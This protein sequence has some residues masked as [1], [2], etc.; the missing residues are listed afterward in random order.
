MIGR[1]AACRLYFNAVTLR[2]EIDFGVNDMP[3]AYEDFLG[4]PT[5]VCAVAIA[6]YLPQARRIFR[7]H[8]GARAIS[9]S[10]WWMWI[11]AYGAL[12]L[13]A[14]FILNDQLIA[15][16]GASNCLACAIVVGLTHI[17][18][19]QLKKSDASILGRR[20]GQEPSFAP[21]ALIIMVGPLMLGY[22]LAHF[23][24]TIN[25]TL[26]SRLVNE[27]SLDPAA[28]GLMTSA[29]FLAVMVMQLPLGV[30]LDR[31]GP[32]V[33][34][35]IC[36]LFTTAGAWA[37][38]LADDI[39]SLFW[40]RALIGI[41]VASA[42]MSGL[43]A[44][45][46]WAPHDRIGLFNGLYI[47]FGTTGAIIA[48]APTEW[49]LH[50][51]TWRQLF[52]GA[53][54]VSAVVAL[55]TFC[56]VPGHRAVPQQSSVTPAQARFRDIIRDSRFWRLAPV[57]A[58]VIGG[59]WALQGLWAAPWLLYVA[60]LSPRDVAWCLLVMAVALC[61]GALAFG[62]TIDRL[63]RR[64]IRPHVLLAAASALFILAECAIATGWCPIPIVAW[65][66]VATLGAGTA[67][68][69]TIMAGFVRKETIA[70]GNCALNMLHFGA[71]FAMQWL[72]GLILEIWPRDALGHH[73][74]EAFSA[75]I[76]ALIVL[77]IPALAWFLWPV[78]FQYSGREQRIGQDHPH[79]QEGKHRGSLSAVNTHSYLLD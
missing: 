13:H 25:S 71:A 74:P 38:A 69:F 3:L 79:R 30:A 32:R 9:L 49:L 34:Q 52:A 75:A 35:V 24:R 28:L 66:V 48:S 63:A 61:A 72:F 53:G 23:F 47:G 41:G 14:V 50:W 29:Y 45:A 55:A 68:S 57:S 64:G 19:R 76:A 33:V 36:L 67:I 10:S 8:S 78:P 2:N 73:A 58:L 20:Q 46:I 40:S 27:F 26:S 42:L 51:M 70:K 16:L 59:A 7:D 54:V 15:V 60:N 62:F 4:L 21:T 43:K 77:Q 56:F 65:M 17:K 18:R 5:L 37:F 6:S 22:F 31:F 12:T 39:H 11:A 44:I 1:I